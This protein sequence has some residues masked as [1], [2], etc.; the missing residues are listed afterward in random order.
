M[1]RG[2][3]S[4]GDG[5]SHLREK[6]SDMKPARSAR[7]F[8][9]TALVVLAARAA[10]AAPPH[11]NTL[12]DLCPGTPDPCVVS[13]QWAIANGKTFDLGGRVL[14]VAATGQ[15]VGDGG[16]GALTIASSG[17]C[18][19]GG[20]ILANGISGPGGLVTVTC[21]G[22]ISLLS[23]ALMQAKAAPVPG[24]G[25]GGFVSLN[26]GA[27]PLTVAAGS[28]I[29]VSAKGSDGGLIVLQSADVCTSSGKLVANA[30][31]LQGVGGFGGEV[32]FQCGAGVSLNAGSIAAKGAAGPM[33]GGLGGIIL[34]DGGLGSVSVA[35]KVKM[36]AS[37]KGDDGGSIE[38]VSGGAC[39]LAGK[40]RATT[41]VVA[42]T[43]GFGGDVSI[44]C[45]GLTL[46][47]SSFIMAAG[48]AGNGGFVELDAGT[49]NLDVSGKINVQGRGDFGG[50]VS[51]LAIG[52]CTVDAKVQADGKNKGGFFGP[53]GSITA[54]CRDITVDGRLTATSPDMGGFVALEGCDVT[55]GMRGAADTSG[56]QGGQ[57]HLIAHDGLTISG[58]V[59][60]TSSNPL[61]SP[62]VNVLQYRNTVAILDPTH[63]QPATTPTQNL[64]LGA[65]P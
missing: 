51:L 53:G 58:F 64:G 65:C 55:V 5:A 3:A 52:N 34:V 36:D 59:L 4:A 48:V 21:A 32:D 14:V 26:A 17:P 45:N 42:G 41:G 2:I 33:I 57:N 62:G 23:G 24:A 27:G 43:G 47:A 38:V 49:G 30:G 22:G 25:F 37:T 61:N 11:A 19:F 6:G 39:T 13:G 10:L 60:A 56:D 35:S 28:K 46:D 29:D 50:D 7:D 12:A 20:D 40:I 9:A 8:L 44:G 15:L 16:A 54:T 63:V 1:P 18:S 31:V